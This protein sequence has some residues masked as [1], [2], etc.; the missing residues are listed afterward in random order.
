[1]SKFLFVAFLFAA[2]SSKK[3]GFEFGSPEIHESLGLLLKSWRN[4]KH[5]TGYKSFIIRNTSLG[6]V[7]P[8]TII[9]SSENIFAHHHGGHA[10]Q[11]PAP[12][13]IF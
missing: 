7:R 2:S 11:L 8:G 10:Q 13:F 5:Q 3:G 6:I 12:Q 4:R 1:M 9:R